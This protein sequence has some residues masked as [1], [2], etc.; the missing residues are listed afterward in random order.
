MSKQTNKQEQKGLIKQPYSAPQ[1]LENFDEIFIY[2][3]V[4]P[5]WFRLQSNRSANRQRWNTMAECWTKATAWKISQASANSA[6]IQTLQYEVHE[7]TGHAMET[8]VNTRCSFGLPA[9]CPTNSDADYEEARALVM[10][11]Q[12]YAMHSQN[13]SLIWNAIVWPFQKIEN[14]AAICRC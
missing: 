8:R 11:R 10:L 4:T 7:H 1:C 6:F 13:V 2:I 14:Q 3:L 9:L 12:S 5:N